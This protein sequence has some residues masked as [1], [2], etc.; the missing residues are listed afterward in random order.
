MHDDKQ[1]ILQNPLVRDLSKVSRILASPAWAF[2][3]SE[4]KTISSN[5]YRPLQY[6]TYAILYTFLGPSPVGYHL[7]KLGMH[8]AVCLVGF[9]CLLKLCC[10]EGIPFVA[11]LLFAVHPVNMEA[12]SWISGIT[13]VSCAL[14]FILALGLYLRSPFIRSVTWVFDRFLLRAVC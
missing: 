14:F 12:V 11:S 2:R 5:Y 4:D 1:E 8:V 3:T 13:D 9:W 10:N 6:L 7:F